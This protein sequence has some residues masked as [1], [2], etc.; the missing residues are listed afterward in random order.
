[1]VSPPLSPCPPQAGSWCSRLERRPYVRLIVLG[2]EPRHANGLGPRI[3]KLPS[4][5]DLCTNESHPLTQTSPCE[6]ASKRGS[7]SFM[8][9]AVPMAFSAK[10]RAIRA[11]WSWRQLV[12]GPCCSSWRKPV[13]SITSQ[14]SPSVEASDAAH[15]KLCSSSRSIEGEVLRVKPTT[16]SKRPEERNAS[17]NALPMPPPASK[18]TAML[19]R[20]NDPMLVPEACS[21]DDA[22]APITVVAPGPR[23][24]EVSAG[25][26]KA[27]RR[28]GGPEERD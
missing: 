9:N 15:S 18:T 17:A 10:A 7:T 24:R 21:V 25:F 8:I 23:A 19:G 28:E 13:A 16:S 2:N 12:S 3:P 26:R 4:E 11:A 22:N 27:A 14:S 20:G 5:S 6:A 1:M